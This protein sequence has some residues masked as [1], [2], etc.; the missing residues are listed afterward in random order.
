MWLTYIGSLRFYDYNETKEHYYSHFI[1]EVTDI[2]W[3]ANDN[4]N[5]KRESQY[6]NTHLY[7]SLYNKPT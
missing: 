2:L 7:D 3:F 4:T 1:D 6:S 5:H